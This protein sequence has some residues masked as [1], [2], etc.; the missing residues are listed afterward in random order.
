MATM[1]YVTC[2]I[3]SLQLFLSLILLLILVSD[4]F[5]QAYNLDTEV[6]ILKEGPPDSFFGYSV[7]FH[8]I[9]KASGPA[10][11]V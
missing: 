10:E 2:Y 11:D 7:A 9:N 4:I 1:A 6:Y 8:R 3:F 5:T